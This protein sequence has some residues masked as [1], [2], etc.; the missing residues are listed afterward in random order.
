[1]HLDGKKHEGGGYSH[2]RDRILGPY[3]SMD[4]VSFIN[5]I[6]NKASVRIEGVAILKIEEIQAG[7]L[8]A[9]KDYHALVKHY[10]QEFRKDN[11]NRGALFEAVGF[12]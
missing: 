10:L 1:M 8:R 7:N 11:L 9:S 4:A 3:Q 2:L 6:R 12:C 5:A